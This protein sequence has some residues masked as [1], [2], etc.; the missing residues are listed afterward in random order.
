M[1]SLNKMTRDNLK[2][3]LDNMDD[4]IKKINRL[5]MYYYRSNND[6]ELLYNIDKKHKLSEPDCGTSAC[7]L[8]LCP[9]IKGLEPSEVVFNRYNEIIWDNYSESIFPGL[10][11]IFVQTKS[12]NV[13]TFKCI[14]Y[15]DYLFG[16]HNPNSL[17]DAKCRIQK[18]LDID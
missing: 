12:N 13:S 7:L 2:I 5:D 14:S 1:L 15:W 6:L 18:I 17:E 11:K 3:L 9:L 4:A 10:R 8:G 16:Q